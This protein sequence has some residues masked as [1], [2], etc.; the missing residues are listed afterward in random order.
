MLTTHPP[1]FVNVNCERPP[2]LIQQATAQQQEEFNR[3]RADREQREIEARQAA[4]AAEANEHKQN[5]DENQGL[6]DQ[7][8]A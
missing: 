2:R 7:K 5:V 8:V 6:D 3:L 4:E 1:Q